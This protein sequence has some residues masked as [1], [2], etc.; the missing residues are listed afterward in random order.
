MPITAEFEISDTDVTTC[1]ACWK[2]PVQA[3]RF[4]RDGSKR[5]LLCTSCAA[6]DYAVRVELFPPLGV[7]RLTW[8][9]VT[10]EK[11]RNPGYPEPPPNPGPPLPSPPPSPTPGR[12]PV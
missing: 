12:P 2:E 11:H 9:K 3:C 4:T 1:E 7:Y 5:D 6:Q 10:M 8:P